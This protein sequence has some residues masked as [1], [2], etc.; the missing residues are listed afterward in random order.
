MGLLLITISILIVGIVCIIVGLNICTLSD[1]DQVIEFTGVAMT[2]ISGAALI[3]MITALCINYIGLDGDVAQ[4]TETYRA[5]EYKVTSEACRD[6]F[7]LLSKEV[8]DEVQAWN[9]E[10]IRGKTMQ[11]DPWIGVFVPDVYDQFE[12]IDYTKYSKE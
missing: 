12:L 10:I 9:E 4:H 8:I 3:V 1:A 6:E 7:G 11:H 2:V 5:L